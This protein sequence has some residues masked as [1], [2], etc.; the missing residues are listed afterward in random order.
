MDKQR[1]LV[2]A[3][4]GYFRDIYSKSNGVPWGRA[5]LGAG[6]CCTDT[7]EDDTVTFLEEDED[8]EEPRVLEELSLEGGTGLTSEVWRVNVSPRSVPQFVVSVKTCC[9][10]SP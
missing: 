6:T 8:E 2:F 3:C 1:R 9:P 5:G 10:P 4:I 7:P